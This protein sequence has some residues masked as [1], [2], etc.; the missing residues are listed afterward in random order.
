MLKLLVSVVDEEEAFEAVFGGAN[1]VDVKN[2]IEGSLGANFPRVIKR[3]REVT[4]QNVQV[5]ATVG[6]VPDLPGTVSLAAL[7]VAVSGADYVKVGLYGPKTVGRAIYLMS[8]V[9]KAV[10]EYDAKVKVVAVGYADFLRSRCLNP[11]EIPDIAHRANASVAMI[12]TKIKDGMKLFD[13]LSDTQLKVFVRKSH[14]CGLIAALAGSLTKEDISRVHEIGADIIGI[15]GAAC[16]CND[17][18]KGRVQRERVAEL[19]KAVENNT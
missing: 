14:E 16:E 6:D 10:T 5:S 1:I 13:F 19:A 17:R 2:P 7:G 4:P 15:R 3:V 11:L 8:E 9:C 18:I 12:D